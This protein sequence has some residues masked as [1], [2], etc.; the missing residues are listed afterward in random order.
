MD[1]CPYEKRKFETLICN[2]LNKAQWIPFSLG[3][4]IQSFLLLQTYTRSRVDLATAD[5]NPQLL[6]SR[7]R[8]GDH[9]APG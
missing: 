5:P 7:E 2:V 6:S 3:V 1:G 9:C 4:F 8:K